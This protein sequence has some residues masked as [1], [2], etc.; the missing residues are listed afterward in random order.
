MGV[1][2][3]II[4]GKCG[5]RVLLE[6]AVPTL[7]R[8]GDEVKKIFLDIYTTINESLRNIARIKADSLSDGQLCKIIL[9]SRVEESGDKISVERRVRLCL[10]DGTVQANT[11]CDNYRLVDEKYIKLIKNV[12]KQRFIPLWKR[13]NITKREANSK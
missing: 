10:P 7:S 1:I 4:K 11:F 12:R 6:T 5:G 8:G 9:T 2:K 3:E 13:K